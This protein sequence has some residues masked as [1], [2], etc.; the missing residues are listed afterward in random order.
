MLKTVV[1]KAFVSKSE[2]CV[3]SVML[4]EGLFCLLS[5]L[6]VCLVPFCRNLGH[7][8]QYLL[9]GSIMREWPSLISSVEEFKVFSGLFCVCI[10]VALCVCLSPNFP[11]YLAA[12]KCLNFSRSL[13]CASFWGLSFS[14]VYSSSLV[15]RCIKVCSLL[16]VFTSHASFFLMIFLACNLA[17]DKSCLSVLQAGWHI[18]QYLR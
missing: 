3:S 1:L 7:L 15:S 6:F 17:W 10:S 16:S 18:D 4:S 13:I 9:T 8:S 11:I 14:I 12:F 5:C 2:A